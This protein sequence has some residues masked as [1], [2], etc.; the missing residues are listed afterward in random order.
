M[1][2][3]NGIYYNKPVWLGGKSNFGNKKNKT[4][5]LTIV[6]KILT[7]NENANGHEIITL[8]ERIGYYDFGISVV[9]KERKTCSVCICGG[10]KRIGG[11]SLKK[12]SRLL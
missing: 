10:R 11:F 2:Y 8:K 12:V 6:L 7:T 5:Q 3:V 4:K 1:G 9:N